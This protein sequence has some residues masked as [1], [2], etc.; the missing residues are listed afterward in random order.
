VASGERRAGSATGAGSVPA[1]R[2]VR[3]SCHRPP[4]ARGPAGSANHGVAAMSSLLRVD[5]SRAKGCRL[6]R[7]HGS[8]SHVHRHSNV[9]R[10]SRAFR[11]WPV[12]ATVDRLGAD[13]IIL[14]R[15]QGDV[16][17]HAA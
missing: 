3:W 11:P 8:P 4:V 6:G 10:D 5:G 15:P 7:A 1:R 2:R 14:L 16:P 13:N 9:D 17:R 12:H